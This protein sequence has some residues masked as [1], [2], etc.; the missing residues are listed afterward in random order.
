MT[1][2][3]YG[4]PDAADLGTPYAQRTRDNLWALREAL[5]AGVSLPG[6]DKTCTPTSGPPTSIVYAEQTAVAAADTPTRGSGA[7]IFMRKTITYS[8]GVPTKVKYEISSDSGSTYSAWTD[9]AGNSF[10]NNTF[11]GPYLSTS[12]WA[13]S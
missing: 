8:S 5:I 7:R 12:V 10:K 13:T 2:F 11:V 3:K 1:Q 6:F 9:L 4:Y